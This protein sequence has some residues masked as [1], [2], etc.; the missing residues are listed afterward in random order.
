[1]GAEQ[2]TGTIDSIRFY[3]YL[4]GPRTAIL[5]G[6]NKSVELANNTININY[7]I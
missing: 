5:H 4:D 3:P 1:M 6:L 7:Q 2:L